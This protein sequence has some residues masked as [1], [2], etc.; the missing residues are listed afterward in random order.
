M[1]VLME[2]ATETITS[3]YVEAGH[4]GRIGDLRGQRVQRPG[5]GDALVRT[6]SVVVMRVILSRVWL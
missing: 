1:F 3:S 5:V 4:L 6:V 2:D